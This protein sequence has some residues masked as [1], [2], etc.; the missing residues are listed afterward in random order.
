MYASYRTVSKAQGWDDKKRENARINKLRHRGMMKDHIQ[1][2]PDGKVI[3]HYKMDSRSSAFMKAFKAAQAKAM[4]E[5]EVKE[6]IKEETP[7]NS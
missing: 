2:T 4:T 5:E 1:I 3:Q 6:E 7:S